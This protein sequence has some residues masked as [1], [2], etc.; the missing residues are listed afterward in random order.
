MIKRTFG[1]TSRKSFLAFGL[2]LVASVWGGATWTGSHTFRQTANEPTA[3][4]TKARLNEMYGQLPLSFEANVG[5]ADPQIDFISRG[6]GYVLFLTP[7]EAV[8][9]L[10]AARNDH[11]SA[12]SAVLRMKFVGSEA[13]PRVVAHEELPGKVN[14][15]IGKDSK[16]WRTGVSTYAKVAYENLY[17]GVDLVYYGNQRQL[18]Y[19]FV[20]RPGTDPQIIAL[21]FEGAAELKVDAQGELVLHTGDGELRQRKPVIYQ[22]VDGVRRE[23]DGSY[24]L[25]DR[26]TVGFQ[27]ADYDASRPLVID[28]VLVYS[29]FLGGS[30]DDEGRDIA[31]DASGNAYVTGS[32]QQLSFPVDFP[33][34]A[35][36]FDTTH[37]GGHD[38]FVTKLNASGSALIYST[39]LGGSNDEFGRGIAVDS[40]GS[41]Y[42]TGITNSA[43][44]PTTVGAFDATL[45]GVGTFDA[46]VTKVN[47]AGSALVYSTFLGGVNSESGNGIAVDTSGSA[48]VTG[49]TGSDNFPTTAG[50]FDTT[51]S[52]DADAFVT[53]LNP[54]ASA[55]VYSTFLGGFDTD[56]GNAIV[57]DTFGSAYVTGFTASGNFPTTV[58]AFDTTQ[59][60]IGEFVRFDAFVTKLNLSGSALVYSTFL[61]GTG[62]EF[63]Q[64]IAV[65][66]SGSAYVTG[67]TSSSDFPTTAGA[68]DTTANISVGSDAFATKLNPSGSALV[69]STFLGGSEL[70]QANDIAVDATGSAYV[71]GF[72]LSA[73]FPITADA[74]DTTQSSSEVF[75]TKFNPAG[76]ALVYSSFLGGD[77][78]DLAFGI[79]V[80]TFG[81]AYVTG[82]TS[83][84]INFPTTIGAFDTTHHVGSFDVF[85]TKIGTISSGVPA[86]VTLNPPAA[87]NTVDSQHCVTATVQDASGSAIAN[88]IVRF[89][90][91]GTVD[92]SGSATTDANGEATFCYV[93]P[94]LP[95]ADTITAFADSDNNNAQDPGEPSGVAEKTWVVP[96]STPLCEITNGGWIIAANGDRANFG[97]NAKADESGE[98]R[99]QQHYQD[100][101]PVRRLNLHSINVLAVVCDG[102]RASIFGQ[103]TIDGSGLFNYRINLQDLGGPGKGQDTYQLLIDG[104]SSGEQTLGGGNVQIRRR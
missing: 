21:S 17:P 68:F 75:V 18:E 82:F 42:V 93:G 35:G 6:S 1:L 27:L 22:E 94:P 55:L 52:Q 62:P 99:G 36:A 45:D 43:N 85:V 29:T 33:T 60:S 16:Q 28:P 81:S 12:S 90:V 79:A 34:T 50:A 104:Y 53:K 87:T 98:T 91:S 73:N 14:Y 54:A 64:G 80:D 38:A 70:D 26:N 30:T 23:V 48:H 37:N 63:G 86:T 25:K 59:N 20:V 100:H 97:G 66:T 84:H 69:Y 15:L 77:I 19:D 13:N 10:R 76:S 83:S 103:A 57:L 102:S 3:A 7:R 44:F 32:T 65:D 2:L 31:V 39:F 72:T 40:S 11:E 51:R 41:A 24:K 47:P 96:A 9:S 61:G 67:S 101:G 58:G 4:A 5:Q 71:T 74:F 89:Q 95:G 46:F 78:T 56:F 49:S 92:T 88:V 8:L